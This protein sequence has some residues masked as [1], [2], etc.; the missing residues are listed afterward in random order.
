MRSLSQQLLLCLLAVALIPMGVVT[1]ITYN[2]AVDS[3]R[4][5]VIED[6]RSVADRQAERV[7]DLIVD[8]ETDTVNLARQPGLVEAVMGLREARG[9]PEYEFRLLSLRPYLSL[10][11][12]TEGFHDAMIID[13]TGEVLI[14]NN[15]EFPPGVLVAAPDREDSAVAHVF[16]EVTSILGV[17]HSDFGTSEAG[18]WYMGV[19]I[20]S[21]SNGLQGALVVHMNEQWV[22]ERVNTYSGLGETGETVLACQVDGGILFVAPTRHDPNAAFRR[23]VTTNSGEATPLQEA[24]RGIRGEG[25]T[26]DYRGEAVLAAWRY[27]PHLRA[28]IV[29]KIDSDEA[30]AMVEGLRTT[31]VLLAGLTLLLIVPLTGALA[32]TLTEPISRLTALTHD[33][34]EGHLDRRADIRSRNEIG[35]LA[36]SINRMAQQIE[37]RE[38]RIRELQTQRF[39]ALVSNIPGVTIRRHHDENE[40]IAFLSKPVEELTGYP[41]EEFVEGDRLL[42]TVIL[43]EDRAPRLQAIEEAIEKQTPWEI[44]FRVTHKNGDIRWALE[45]GQA[46]F[47]EGKA[48]WLDGIILDITAQKIAQEELRESRLAADAANQ[49]KSD[50]L[51]NMSHEIRT[52]M[53][54]V[55]GLTHLALKTELTEKQRDYLVKVETS[56]RSLLGI[57]NDILDFSKVEAGKL[58]MESI[59]FR[60]DEVLHNLSNLLSVRAKDRGLELYVYRTS[61]VPELLI[62]DPMR[63]GQVL[64]NLANNAVKFTEVGEIK[65]SVDVAENREGSVLLRF[66]ITD[67]GV[68]MSEQQM[69]RL[70]QAFTQADTSTTR[71]YG[72]TGLGLTISQRLVG[73]MG[74]TIEVE[75]EPGKGSTFSFTARFGLQPEANSDESRVPLELQGLRVLVVDDSATAREVLSEMTRSLTFETTTVSSGREAIA[76][77]TNNPGY[78]LVLMDWKMPGMSG[79]ETVEKIRETVEP[80]PPIFMVTNYG[81]EEV[82]AQAD[83]IDISAFLVKPVTAS[84]LFDAVSRT[85]G[86][87]TGTSSKQIAPQTVRLSFEGRQVLL[88]EDNEINQQVATELLSALNLEVT[89]ANNGKEAVDLL[90]DLDEHPFEAILMDLQMPVMDGFEATKRI[91]EQERFA[92]IPIIAMTAHALA[93]DRE[94]CLNAGMSDHLTKPI[95]PDALADALVCWLGAGQSVMTDQSVATPL[96][97]L[98]HFQVEDGMSRVNQNADL[99]LKLLKSFREK[100]RE[101]LQNLETEL[102]GDAQQAVAAAHSIKGVA[103]N[104]GAQGVFEAAKELES[105]ARQEGSDID[106]LI[107][108]LARQLELAVTELEQL[109]QLD[110]SEPESSSEES[111]EE[112]DLESLLQDLAKFSKAL[113]EQDA[114][115]EDLFQPIE[116]PLKTM[117]FSQETGQI[118]T[119]MDDFA[120]DEATSI[121]EDIQTRLRSEQP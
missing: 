52:P 87:D 44:E 29:V 107:R 36:G 102:S 74:G 38:Q 24:V 28:A 99:Y 73:M 118:K 15:L 41:P 39:Q 97:E 120:F 113:E 33:L 83:R 31:V 7:V 60:L 121:V 5:R 3:L 19:P 90:A 43:R 77:L 94:R 40:T 35:E 84:L 37:E 17:A 85:F 34:A 109:D 78:Q 57:I 23:I 8:W 13:R 103:G 10:F 91:R 67:T 81:R 116:G 4:T 9:T 11:S 89:I 21:P 55:I 16:Q 79:I 119:L 1:T 50:F 64:V 86:H 93:G 56:A 88:V 111:A 62:G 45:R 104:L 22:N 110:P 105:Q 69:S 65:V 54:A 58:E 46:I 66:A 98:E 115:C 6:L 26:I 18:Q 100:Y 80:V 82:R 112:V 12:K 49:A 2:R 76:E 96:P 30:F 53:N 101:L 75:S 25:E 47:E 59:E 51:A 42:K 108:E 20:W 27:L 61:A 63:L 72:G 68:G 71:H 14:S 114:F 106:P 117:G 92:D 95:D 48:T 32:R 70:F